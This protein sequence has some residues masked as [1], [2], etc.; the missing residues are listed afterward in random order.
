MKKVADAIAYLREIAATHRQHGRLGEAEV[1]DGHIKALE[2]SQER[3]RHQPNPEIL[4][5]MVG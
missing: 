1:I 3:F 2:D 5:E 4:R